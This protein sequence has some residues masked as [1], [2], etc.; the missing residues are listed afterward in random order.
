MDTLQLKSSKILVIGD[1]CVD[2]YHFGISE[3][4]SPQAPVPIFKLSH[5]EEKQG[6]AGNVVQNLINLGNNVELV[7][8]DEI[9]TK[10]RFV[11]KAS[12]QH[13]MRL[14]TGESSHI[15][16]FI[17]S[18]KSITFKDYDCVVFSDYNKGFLDIE[19]ISYLFNIL[20]KRDIPIFVDSK[21]VDLSYYKNCFVKINENEYKVLKKEPPN[22]GLIVTLGIK[23]AQYKNRIY[24][25]YPSDVDN[26]NLSP[27]VCGAGDTFLAGL[28][29]QYMSTKNI[30]DAIHFANFCGSIAVKNFGTYVIKKEDLKRW[31]R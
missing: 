12:K 1:S 14:D 5:T 27:N 16:S 28:V 19:S 2:K 29:T 15:T 21:K 20:E 10:E 13:L 22:S 31:K 7:T 4:L 30:D 8:N 18:G 11:D 26:T 9:I 23:G 3:R 17:K 25:S 6:M 24:N